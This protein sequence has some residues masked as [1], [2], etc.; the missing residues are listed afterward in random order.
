MNISKRVKEIFAENPSQMPSSVAK[1]L[2]VSELEVIKNLPGE[3]AVSAPAA[4]FEQ[5]WMNMTQWNSVT[6]IVQNSGIIAEIKGKL[7]TGVIFHEH[8]PTP[9]SGA[10]T[11]VRRIRTTYLSVSVYSNQPPFDVLLL[12]FRCV[13]S[14]GEM[15]GGGG[16]ACRRQKVGLETSVGAVGLFFAARPA[17]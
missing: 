5:I 3:M 4:D 17:G 1:E 12:L 11:R 15:A 9:F 6:A 16:R 8:S 2:G 7:S 10:F 14:G 13:D